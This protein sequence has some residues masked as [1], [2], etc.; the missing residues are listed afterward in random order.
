MVFIIDSQNA[1]I[2]GNMFIGALVDMGAD[3]ERLKNLMEAVASDFGEVEVSI[4]KT[5]KAGIACTFCNVKTLHPEH[6]N[7]HHMHF[8]EF[9]EKI[10]GLKDENIENLTDEMVEKAKR[11]FTRIALSESRVHGTTLENVHFH[12]VGAADAVADVFGSIYAY[13][14][15]EMDKDKVVALP[16]AVGGGTVKTAHGIIPVPAP[17]SLDILKGLNQEDYEDILKGEAFF[18]GG[19]VDS[20]LATPTGCALYMELADEFLEFAPM[21]SPDKVAYGCGS[22]DFDFPN[23][24]RVI[25]SRE[26]NPKKRV[27]V[28]ETNIDHMS[29]EE[30]GYLF[31]LLLIEGASDV[32]MVP[33]TMKKNRPGHLIKVISNPRNVDNLVD[34]LFKET[35]TLGIRVS[36]NTHRGVAERK[37]IPIDININDHIYTI[38]FKI[39]LIGDEMISHR[40]EYED[41]RRIAA[42]QDIP[43]S[44]IREIAATMIRDYLENGY[45]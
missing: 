30:L 6:E 22:K 24:L 23:V 39:G 35:G 10:D 8:P 43:L 36:E 29:G 37:F 34:V 33:I 21:M 20:E 14:D 2:S 41:L 40:A 1:G 44:E 7:N 4:E 38:N 12:E 27:S 3:S 18:K 32:S 28:I 15:L 45:V 5:T 31:D 13:F 19:P 26:I 11:V 25:K 17:A 9:I 42:E 16:I